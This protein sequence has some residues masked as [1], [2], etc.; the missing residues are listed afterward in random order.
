MVGY[1]RLIWDLADWYDELWDTRHLGH[2]AKSERYSGGGSVY[3]LDHELG[4]E[5]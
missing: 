4:N 2:V 5:Q 1:G 3:V